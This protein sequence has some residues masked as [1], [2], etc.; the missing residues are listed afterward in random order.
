MDY[1]TLVGRSNDL[2]RCLELASEQFDTWVEEHINARILSIESQIFH[3]NNQYHQSL[4]IVFRD[5]E[6][7]TFALTA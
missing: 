2:D 4:F 7:I 5:M 6:D 1:I 3:A